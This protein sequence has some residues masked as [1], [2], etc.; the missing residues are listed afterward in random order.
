MSEP[1]V[2]GRE[3]ETAKPLFTL[4][5]MQQVDKPRQHWSTRGYTSEGGFYLTVRYPLGNP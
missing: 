2:A 3:S 1:G 5:P 4:C